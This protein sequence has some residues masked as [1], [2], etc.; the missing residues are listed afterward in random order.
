MA[1]WHPIPKK[2]ITRWASGTQGCQ[3]TFHLPKP[4]GILSSLFQLLEE[5]WRNT[6]I[7][8]LRDFRQNPIA[9]PNRQ[10][11]GTVSRSPTKS[12]PGWKTRAP[13][14]HA[15]LEETSLPKVW[16]VGAGVIWAQFWWPLPQ[17]PPN[18]N[19]KGC[20]QRWGSG[21]ALWLACRK[22]K[23]SDT[24]NHNLLFIP[25]S[26]RSFAYSW[27]GFDAGHC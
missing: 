16:V 22:L 6:H 15:V 24:R 18:M 5:T 10:T 7:F 13:K 20:L 9:T 3:N 21:S 4:V 17:N 19:K 23:P 1:S 14:P 26:S 11:R 8:L 25:I 12:A 2:P 27:A